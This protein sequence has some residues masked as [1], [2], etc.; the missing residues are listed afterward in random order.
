MRADPATWIVATRA[1]GGALARAYGARRIAGRAWLAPRAR[2]R[3]LAAAL[4]ARGLLD[5]AEPNRLGRRAQAPAPDPLSPQAGWR[6]FV[7]G[8]QVPPA[9]TPDSPLIGIVDTQI[10]VNHPEV[11][12][13]NITTL[14][15]ASLR[16]SHG[17][18]TTTVAAAPANGVGFLGIWPGARALNV[19]LPDGQAISCA[20]SVGGIR[21]ALR[22][23]AA[24]VNMSYGSPSRC[25]TEEHQIL[26]AIKAGAVPV[27]ASGN[28]FENGNPL[29][30]PASL[31]HVITVGAIGP[32]DRPTR[33]S[34]ESV[35]LDLS[36]PG[37]CILAGVPAAFDADGTADGFEVR[38]TARRSPPRWSPPPSPGYAPRAR[39]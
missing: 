13:S 6:E 5:Y 28:E 7:T 11:V 20:D 34:N 33:F 26:R 30:F 36:A 15:G 2:T 27:A 39:S 31:P 16:D 14:G 32:D 24:V 38:R 21:R 4:R 35:A 37:E 23:G 18:A 3:A 10:D 19:P 12:G 25:A 1:G 29:E 17:T 8:D 9:V 22:N